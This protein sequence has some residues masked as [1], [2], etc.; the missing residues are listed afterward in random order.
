[1]VRVLGP[2]AI[3]APDTIALGGAKPKRLLA[4][5]LLEPGRPLADDSLA[6]LVWP[7]GPPE[8]WDTSLRAYVSRLRRRF[9]ERGVDI[10][11]DRERAGYV[12]V[13]NGA[14]L[15][16]DA[17]ERGFVEADR[18]LTIG[19]PGDGAAALAA[20]L[21]RWR[22][23]PFEDLDGHLDALPVVER[24]EALRLQA[25]ELLFEARLGAGDRDGLVAELTAFVERHPFRERGV[26]QLMRTLYSLGRQVDALALFERTRRR[27]IEEL[28]V[29]PGPAL[30]ELH[31]AVL[32]H[33]AALERSSAPLTVERRRSPGG[34][35]FTG[36]GDE[37]ARIDAEVRPGGCLLV[38][39][40]GG[41]GKSRLVAQ[42]FSGR[43]VTLL[44][45]DEPGLAEPWSPWAGALR[46]LGRSL[47]S[48][49]DE[50]A[51]L[52]QLVEELVGA[53]T[54]DV[55]VVDDLHW[56]D[57]ASLGVFRVLA[58][59]LARTS[60]TLV[61]TFRRDELDSGA[62]V[63]VASLESEPGTVTIDL[64][65]FDPTR[66]LQLVTA[67]R[68][69]APPLLAE[70]H[71]MCELSGGSPF[72]LIQLD[73]LVRSGHTLDELGTRPDLVDAEWANSLAGLADEL[74]S[75]HRG[76]VEL[77]A[78]LGGRCAPGLLAIASGRSRGV[79][80]AATTA[81]RTSGLISP[82]KVDGELT[83]SHDLVR[84]TVL[85]AM[86]D[87]HEVALSAA[88]RLR[89]DGS[90]APALVSV[91]L[92]EAGELG[93]SVPW[94]FD[95]HEA[96]AERAVR[97]SSWSSA[98][99][100]A[101]R[102]ELL[103][104]SL[105][106]GRAARA[107]L[108]HGEIACL[109]GQVGVG[110][111][112]LLEGA[113]LASRSGDV[114]LQ[115]RAVLASL[116]VPAGSLELGP[117][118]AALIDRLDAAEELDERDRVEIRSRLALLD[119]GGQ[120]TR[121]AMGL[122]PGARELAVDVVVADARRTGDPHLVSRALLCELL[123]R[124]RDDDQA[125]RLRE[126]QEYLSVVQTDQPE[127]RVT[128][129]AHAYEAAWA[130]GRRSEAVA[131]LAELQHRADALGHVA[132]RW[133]VETYAIADDIAAGRYASAEE[134]SLAALALA[135]D[136]MGDQ[137]TAAFGGQ[138]VQLRWFQGRL[139]ELDGLVQVDEAHEANTLSLRVTMQLIG[140][141]APAHAGQRE[142]VATEVDA[143]VAR[144]GLDSLNRVELGMLAELLTMVGTPGPA[145]EIGRRLEAAADE[146]IASSGFVYRLAAASAAGRC[147]ALV[148]E[149][150]RA[151][152]LFELGVAAERAAELT[153]QRLRSEWALAGS[154][155]RRGRPGDRPRAEALRAAAAH[156]ASSIGLV[157][158][159]EVR[160]AV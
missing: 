2:L 34:V 3:D 141:L 40:P 136:A 59:R 133:Y 73:R 24:L 4:A 53:L 119:H 118:L 94:A 61:A 99:R 143:L 81:A 49:E 97:E 139:A 129:I 127:G 115:R 111:R 78:L 145:F 68:G 72:H 18:L 55:I 106:V 150:D 29:E 31:H 92:A 63:H 89:D 125:R 75:E 21:D 109:A 42:A 135:Q 71:R 28:G 93:A 8:R 157:L 37:L 96:A 121:T 20:V 126:A 147:A 15:D 62:E 27:L 79:V 41:I 123:V 56:A 22:G 124:L 138:I 83:V 130:L 105:D 140:L 5:L 113:A 122:G 6:E 103:D 70:L 64:T 116:D 117:E 17:F 88:R 65:P 144:E 12:A 112:R 148:G 102:T 33:D 43:Q 155:D 14:E 13:L 76:V 52:H 69:G 74:D 48:G 86:S 80:D 90:A 82:S 23:R 85:A 11:I 44:G 26:G 60:T 149:L 95:V 159:A 66:A 19:R 58:R 30:V 1:M 47:P 91:L 132:T 16:A 57:G 160:P 108:R 9:E 50:L 100:A 134:R 151:V 36:R 77:L 152:E 46:T 131:H 38:A 54:S 32:S 137:A 142:V 51:L 156:G 153:S 35:P 120:L 158:D 110:H 87:R 101:R 114:E 104:P 25:V 67:L 39:G 128:G 98:E 45:C 84:S 7:D 146:M 10:A 107:A 154:L